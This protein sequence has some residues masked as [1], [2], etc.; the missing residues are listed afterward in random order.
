MT[1]QRDSFESGR[2]LRQAIADGLSPFAPEADDLMCQVDC[3]ECYAVE[4]DG[5]CPHGFLSAARTIGV[6]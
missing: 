2:Q 5:I 1:V 3:E 6:I 4:P